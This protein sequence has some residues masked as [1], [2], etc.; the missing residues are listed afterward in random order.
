MAVSTF[1]AITIGSSE[2]S[3]KIYEISSKKTINQIDNIRYPIEL[4]METYSNGE[5]SH[6]IVHSV[7]SVLQDF[8][9]IMK[10]YDISDYTAIA[11]SAIREASNCLLVLDRIKLA[12]GLTVNVVSNSTQRLLC[13]EALAL[14]END[15]N[16]IIDEDSL[17]VDIG[18]G[19]IQLSLFKD[20]V[21]SSTQNIKL[22][23]LRIKELL[24]NIA[25]NITDYSLLL[26]ELLNNDLMTYEGLFIDEKKIKNII[27]IS[28]NIF[29]ISNYF[30][31]AQGNIIDSQEFISF[32]NKLSNNSNKQI[33][34]AFGISSE[35]LSLLFPITMI[36]EKIIE[37]SGANKIWFP[38][39]N[40]NDG[41]VV[42]YAVKKY[43]FAIKHDFSLDSIASAKQ[44]ATK[45]KC[46]L[47]HNN[48]VEENALV[49]FDSLSKLH[50]L[51]KR[52][53]I[54]L[55]IAIML[56]N[57]GEFINM[58]N[59]LFNS[60]HI[61]LQTEII[62][63]SHEEREMIAN[64]IDYNFV[65]DKTNPDSIRISKLAAILR[66]ANSL[67]KS[68][69]Q[70]IKKIKVEHNDNEIYISFICDKDITLEKLFF[71]IQAKYFAMVY[72]VVPKLKQKK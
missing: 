72:G 44:I 41:V 3:M 55:R 35:A 65:A 22:G 46:N 58:R 26:K 12:T 67:D 16:K 43:K 34:Q 56:H 7:C 42:E 29:D 54:L 10:E 40:V 50:G 20:S 69:L 25:Y 4:G 60:H 31:G 21:L 51:G 23:F 47:A 48:N 52:E 36:I 62:G 37:I 32:Y 6:E 49:L 28:N 19:S 5:L 59:S 18:A 33:N 71:N 27:V 8:C 9:K 14:K 38:G 57:C 2:I 70:K 30:S 17:I 61:I 39:V 13:F 15:F 64:I 68:H 45:Y 53:R 63:I 11:T 24:S 1:A 66:L